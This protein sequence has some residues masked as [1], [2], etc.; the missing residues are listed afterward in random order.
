MV[1]ILKRKLLPAPSTPPIAP[2]K[3]PAAG[4]SFEG[5]IQGVGV[6]DQGAGRCFEGGVERAVGG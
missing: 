4:I 3:P 1:E 2:S 5:A 6:A